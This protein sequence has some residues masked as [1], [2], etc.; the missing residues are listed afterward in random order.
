MN[1]AKVKRGVVGFFK[2]DT[3]A[4]FVSLE[5][6]TTITEATGIPHYWRDHNGCVSQFW[7]AAEIPKN[8]AA[9]CMRRERGMKHTFWLITDP[10]SDLVGKIFVIGHTFKDRIENEDEMTFEYLNVSPTLK[11]SILAEKPLTK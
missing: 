10:E 3:M 9:M 1:Q 4:P 6:F 8:T 2:K 5:E 7:H 11:H